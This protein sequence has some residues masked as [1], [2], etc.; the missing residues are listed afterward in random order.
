MLY[1]KYRFIL[2]AACIYDIFALLPFA[3]SVL[4]QHNLNTLSQVDMY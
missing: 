3:L 1:S 4:N 2:K